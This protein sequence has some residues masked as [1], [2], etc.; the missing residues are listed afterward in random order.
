MDQKAMKTAIEGVFKTYRFHN[1][2]NKINLAE[3]P[4]EARWCQAID[5]V[6]SNLDPDEQLLIRERYMKRERITD[7]QVYS[8]TFDPS[9]SA[10]TYMK[11]RSR[12]FEKL[13]QAFSMLGLLS[14]E[15]TK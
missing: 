3:T 9:I 5:D 8:F 14:G 10:V 12:A 15:G 13:L 11:I 4:E 1:F 7:L 6:V 2:I